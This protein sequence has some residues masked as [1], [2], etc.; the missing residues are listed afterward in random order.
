MAKENPKRLLAHVCRNRRIKQ[1]ITI[2]ARNY[3]TMATDSIE[4]A[5]ILTEAYASVFRINNQAPSPNFEHRGPLMLEPIITSEKSN[6][7]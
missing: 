5:R 6:V 3:G 2:L 7:R 1:R 4:L